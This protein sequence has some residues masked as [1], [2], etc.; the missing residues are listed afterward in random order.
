M[1]S[2]L[3][4]AALLIA[5]VP[6]TETKLLPID[7]GFL[8][9]FGSAVA[10]DGDT[11]VIGAP[12][13][14][15]EGDDAGAAYVFVHDGSSWIEQAK[16]VA[17]DASASAQFGNAVALNGDTLVVG[18][19][20]DDANGVQSGAAY[21][22]VRSGTTWSQQARLEPSDPGE[23]EGFGST[24]AID[25]DT[26]AVGAP[27]DGTVFNGTGAVYVFE[28]GGAV[29]TQQSKLV[30]DNPRPGN[31]LG[32]SVSLSG[33]TIVTGS[34]FDE[35]TGILDSGAVYVFSRVGT[36]W[37]KQAELRAGDASPN[38]H[39]GWSVSVNGDTL[40][41]GAPDSVGTGSAYVF[42]RT[43]A[44]WS[45]Q[46]KLAADDALVGD[47]FGV[48][49]SL[50]G[51]TAAVGA[52]SDNSFVVDGGS[53]YLFHRSGTTWSQE[54]EI[55]ALDI[56]GSDAFG[57]SVGI[58]GATVVVGAPF[59]GFLFDGAAYV[60]ASEG[61]LAP[62]ADPQS[63]TTAEDTATTLTLTGSDPEGDALTFTVLTGPAKGALTGTPPNLVYTPQ[64]NQNGAD[65]FTFKV[66]DGAL[67]SA[68]ATVSITITPV[69]DAPVADSQAVTTLEDTAAGV[70]L[71]GNDVDADAL[72]F[73]VLSAPT[74]GTL[75]GTAPNLTYTPNLNANGSD[76]F[77][78]RANDGALDSAAAT[79]SITITPVNDAPAAN[80]QSVTTLEDT[81]TGITLTG[82]DVENDALT[83]TVLTAPT[84]GV[85]S[86][87]APNLTY[88][89]NLNENGSDSF[90]F[91]ANDG[92][93]DSAAATVSI[94]ITP[95][96]D[97]PVA[98]GQAVTTLEDTATAIT[99]TGSD[100]E[101]APLTFTVLTSPTKGALS[102]TAPNL[103]YTPNPNANGSDSFTFRVNDGALDSAAATVSIAITPVNDTPTAVGQGLA[104]PRNIPVAIQ[105]TGADG[106]PETAQT[107][108][109][110]IVEGPSLGTLSGFDPITGRLLYTPALDSEGLDGFTFT[111]T[112]D[113]TAGGPA[114]TSAPA[115][116]TIAISPG[117][118]L[119][120]L[121]PPDATPSAVNE[122][123][124]VTVSG[125]L[126]DS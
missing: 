61:N 23:E 13:D 86:G 122:N 14:S 7:S 85:L 34:P 93:L 16:L 40:I 67:D 74:K 118:G 90:T 25:A 5:Q 28:R 80:A 18:A 45:Q 73:T 78:F 105:L 33:D 36:T 58:S 41:A 8:Q 71:T 91:R 56:A 12:G 92:A 42:T 32:H 120:V 84:K 123:D 77:T 125:L 64:P 111:V 6:N 47:S 35:D 57:F 55:G 53:V 9:Q 88:T 2:L 82:S 117:N 17:D 44:V 107:L 26:V 15:Q 121:S 108:T 101:N 72:T 109:F 69:N 38:S 37:S 83:F 51:N 116:V 96:N 124:T 119:P 95:V 70:T 24:V 100:M 48:T 75:S 20:A 54:A 21:V 110:A 66:N 59:A 89:P 97:G 52:M 4:V 3:I 1:L 63:V 30:S 11:A 76:S 106:D 31:A 50:D 68:P 115:T 87:A 114:L 46:A 94:I 29:W 98:N 126:T 81:A 62:V 103:T 102:G 10:I 49:V 43:L 60:F 112:D 104:T 99:L 27:G 19:H 39:L 22:F 79:V 65:S 113:A